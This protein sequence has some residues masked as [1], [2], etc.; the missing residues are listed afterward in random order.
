MNIPEGFQ[1]QYAIRMPNGKLATWGNDQVCLFDDRSIAEQTLNH[2]RH[3][4]GGIGVT[5]YGGSVVH[6]VR[7]A[8]LGDDEPVQGLVSSL[9]EWLKTQ[10]GQS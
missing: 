3:M 5:E 9:E 1:V 6:S 4:A 2:L 8:W 10:G 7:T